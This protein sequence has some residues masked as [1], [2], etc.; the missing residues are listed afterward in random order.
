MTL[1]TQP[2]CNNVYP[3]C[4]GNANGFGWG[5]YDGGWIFQKWLFSSARDVNIAGRGAIQ[6][7]QREGAHT[8]R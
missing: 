3:L 2:S 1:E 6:K 5:V 4:G 7:L 8:G